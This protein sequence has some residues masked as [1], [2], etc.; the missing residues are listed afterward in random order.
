MKNNNNNI[1]KYFCNLYIVLQ[2]PNPM[3]SCNIILDNVHNSSEHDHDTSDH[4]HESWETFLEESDSF[5]CEIDNKT[6]WEESY[7]VSP[8]MKQNPIVLDPMHKTKLVYKWNYYY[9]LPNDKNWNLDSYKII[10]SDLDSVEKLIAI[11]ESIPEHIIK[12]C[13][14]FVMKSW[15]TPMWEDTNN[16]NGGCFSYKVSNKVVTQVWRDL[17]YLLCGNELT[18]DKKS[19]EHVNGITISP[20][21]GFCIIKIWFKNCNYQDPNTIVDIDNLVKAGCLFKTHKAEY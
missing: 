17:M 3:M 7:T 8:E 4:H 18:I 21:R 15:I 16:R 13:M 20:K 9:H 5:S 1:E 19:M 12:N 14:L 2:S 6:K 11:N 10:I